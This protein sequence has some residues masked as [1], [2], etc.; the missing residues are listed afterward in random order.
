[1]SR[2]LADARARLPAWLPAAVV[3]AA[4][5]RQAWLY[6]RELLPRTSE[7]FSLLRPLAR[8]EAWAAAGA[9]PRPLGIHRVADPGLD[10]YGP[11][12]DARQTL[13]T[14]ESVSALL[15]RP[16]PAAALIRL[17]ELAPLYQVARNAKYPLHVLDASNRD[18][19]LIANT[20]PP[21]AADHNPIREVLFDAPPPLAHET[22]LRFEDFVEVIA[23]EWDEPV[24]RGREVELRVVLRPLRPLP[25]GS[26]ITVRLQRG[27]LSR[28]NPLA[29]D[30]VENIYPPQHWRAG[31]YLLH[32]F[33]VQVPTL[34]V[35]PGPHEVVMG[36]Q[37]TASANYKITVPEGETGEHGVRVYAGPHE[38]AVVGEV[39]VW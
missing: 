21:G 18:V 2:A 38:F 24:V 3:A 11:P 34:E 13:A 4:L 10:L 25:S 7:Q 39:Q 9:L 15:R 31:D 14:R 35:V 36:L 6:G 19:L 23:W 30:L 20:L 32:R 16:E 27:R 22:L 37:R 1:M 29:H 5:G 12:P 26:K 28:V 17:S 33:R 8:Y